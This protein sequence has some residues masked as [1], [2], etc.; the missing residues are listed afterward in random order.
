MTR[1]AVVVLR[2][3]LGALFVWSAVTKVPD[4]AAF[5]QDV[6]NYRVLPAVLVPWAA[7]AVVGVEIIC[8]IAL[9]TGV[10]ARPAA[11][12]TA[13]LLLAF[14]AFLAQALLR[15]I[16]LRCGCFGGDEPASWWTVARD[17]VMLAAALAVACMEKPGKTIQ[18]GSYPQ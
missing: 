6:A 16:D 10:L 17:L 13:I 1:I 4:M 12:L 5:A 11:V 7:A 3:V 8:G 2:V 15:G 18:A 14:T 9:V